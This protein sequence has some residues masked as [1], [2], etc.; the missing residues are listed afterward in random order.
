MADTYEKGYTIRHWKGGISPEKNRGPQGSFAYGQGLDIRSGE[1]ILTCNQALVKNSGTTVTDLIRFFVPAS[2]G[3]LFGFGDTGKIYKKTPAGVWSLEYTDPDGAIMGAGEYQHN[4]GSGSYVDYLY[5]GTQTKHKRVL[6][7]DA[8]AGTWSP[9]T[10][11]TYKNGVSGDWHVMRSAVGVLLTTDGEHMHMVDYEGAMNDAA[12]RLIPGNA[13]T[14]LLDRNDRVIIGS[15]LRTQLDGWLW[16]WNRVND[17]WNTKKSIQGKAVNAMEFL[18]GGIVVQA[19][20]NGTLKF[21]NFAET[22]PLRRI[23]DTGWC[24][25]GG[26]TTYN[27]MPHFGMNG[28]AKNGVYSIGRIDKN[29]P[30]ALNLEYI[31]SHGKLTGTEIGAVATHGG[32]LH[33]AWKDGSTYG[34]DTVSTTVKASGV[35][36]GLWFDGESPASKK[37]S[38]IKVISDPIPEDCEVKVKYMMHHDDT[39]NETDLVNESDDAMTEG[40]SVGIFSTEGEGEICAIRLELTP[41]AN[42]APRVRSVTTLYAEIDTL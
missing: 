36:E 40:M 15:K 14:S 39:W 31:P 12:L 1:N 4:N 34:V 42:N 7:T 19:G 28:G 25:P 35:Y 18:E 11:D 21:W 30:L 26:V 33:V 32:V 27:E 17:S 23:P 20:T 5:W 41:N 22:Y 16:T 9:T 13:G 10:A 37:T 2:N 38:F 24:Y 8:V 3:Y 6:L 29:D